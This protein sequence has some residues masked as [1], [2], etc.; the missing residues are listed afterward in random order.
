M[1]TTVRADE[2]DVG[3]REKEEPETSPKVLSWIDGILTNHCYVEDLEEAFGV[4]KY[5]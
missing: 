3:A 2:L 5:N 1:I 4:E